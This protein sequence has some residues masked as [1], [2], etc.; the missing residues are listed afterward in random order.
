MN[1]IKLFLVTL[2][3]IGI[4]ACGGDSGV[5]TPAANSHTLPTLPAGWKYEGW[6]VI[7]NTAL[8][9][10]TFTNPAAA[11]AATPFAGTNPQP[12]PPFPGEDFLANPPIGSGL[13]FPTDLRNQTVVISIELVEA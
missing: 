10:G 9:T 6:V 2:L 3:S 8:S 4:A 7:G 11:D 1:T 12:T 13:T 5:S